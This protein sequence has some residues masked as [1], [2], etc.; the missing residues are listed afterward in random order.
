[1][2]LLCSWSV[3]MDFAYTFQSSAWASIVELSVILYIGIKAELIPHSKARINMALHSLRFQSLSSCLP[4]CLPSKSIPEWKGQEAHE[5]LCFSNWPHNSCVQLFNCFDMV[6]S[7]DWLLSGKLRKLSTPSG[8][9]INEKHNWIST[10]PIRI[11]KY[12]CEKICF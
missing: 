12:A 3:G 10:S 6:S 2:L 9:A 1:M 5:M 7:V 4:A 8:N 11:I